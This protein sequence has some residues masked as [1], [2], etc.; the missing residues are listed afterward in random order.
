MNGYGSGDAAGTHANG[1]GCLAAQ[2]VA[3]FKNDQGIGG[4]YLKP[5]TRTA[6]WEDYVYKVFADEESQIRVEVYSIGTD[7]PLFSGT[8]T[9][10]LAWIEARDSED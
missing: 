10:M 8:P 1:V 7:E 4:I 2:V 6:L 9:E 5:T 3:H